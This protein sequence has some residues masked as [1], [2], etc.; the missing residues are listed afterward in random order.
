MKRDDIIAFK[1]YVHDELKQAKPFYKR[2]KRLTMYKDNK[3][4]TWGQ[5]IKRYRG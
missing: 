2:V 5:F 3:P 1:E 4:M